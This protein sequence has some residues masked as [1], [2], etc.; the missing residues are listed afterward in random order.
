MNATTAYDQLAASF[1]RIALLNESA[2]I[3]HWDMSAMMPAGGAPGRGEQLAEL[4]AVTHGLMTEDRMADLLDAALDTPPEDPWQA[5]NLRQMRRVWRHATALDED[6]VVALSRASS[7]CEAVWRTARAEA[8]FPAVLPAFTELLDLTREKARAKAQALDL[9]LYDALLDEFEPGLRSADVDRLFAELEAVL[10]GLLGAVRARQAAGP[11]AVLPEGPFPA[12]IQKTLGMKLMSALGFDF[13]HGRLDV[14]LHPF[15]GGTPDD[16][17]IT[18]RYDETDFTTALMGVL[19]ETGHALYERGL[20]EAFRHQ[21]VGGAMGMAVHESQSL[22]IEMQ[23][24]RSAEFLAF[25]GPLMRQAFNGAGPAWDTANLL[26]LYNQVEPGFIRVDA[27]EVT[28]PL[29]VI[30]R[31]RLETALVTG[32]LA[33]A[34]LP[35]AWNDGFKALLGLTPPDDAQGCLQ[36]IH[37]YDGAIGYFPTYTLGALMAAQL[38]AAAKAENPAILPGVATGDFTPLMAWLGSRVHGLGRL[39][40]MP[41][42][43]TGATGAPLGTAAFLDHI[44]HRYLDGADAEV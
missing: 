38:F 35:G 21:P 22:L 19:H 40:S 28:Y 16:V 12:N 42:L 34:D 31:Y 15:C 14:S 43:V 7:A 3:L 32:D 8:D 26:R 13:D 4:A 1:R 39:K 9:S 27:D 33:A 37:W 36:D 17:R 10:P 30:L 29:H 20:P 18:T 44:R 23:V 6:L 11:A 24:C 2:E 25:A 5:A 41:D